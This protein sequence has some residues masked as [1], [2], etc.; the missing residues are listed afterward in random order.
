[1]ERKKTE[2]ERATKQQIIGR[3]LDLVEKGQAP[4]DV[5]SAFCNGVPSGTAW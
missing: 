1:M 5:N 2:D 4:P 3:L